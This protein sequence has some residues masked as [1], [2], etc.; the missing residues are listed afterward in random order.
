MTLGASVDEST[1][2]EEQENQL[3]ESINKIASYWEKMLHTNGGKLELSKCFWVLI[4]WKWVRDV[5]QMKRIHNPNA[6][7][8]IK[9]SDTGNEVNISR[10]E[11]DD[12]PK[13]LGCHMSADGK[14][15][16]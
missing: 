2:Y 11:V 1:E 16:E 14:W 4:S 5:P 12:A 7:M 8:K 9:Q 10:K 15:T 6:T 13:V 3:V